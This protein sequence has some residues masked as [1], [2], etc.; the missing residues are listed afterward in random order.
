ME[1]KENID[2]INFDMPLTQVRREKKLEVQILQKL[3]H[4]RP[5]V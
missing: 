3:W 4:L 2:D 5:R 1:D